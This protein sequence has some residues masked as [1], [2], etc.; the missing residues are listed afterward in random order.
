[1]S[2]KNRVEN[3]LEQEDILGIRE[4]WFDIGIS[5]LVYNEDVRKVYKTQKA[6]ILALLNQEWNK[7]EPPVGW[8]EVVANSYK[9]DLETAEQ[10][11]VATVKV[12]VEIAAKEIHKAFDNQNKN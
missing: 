3:N 1:M 7:Q 6:A 8:M 5:G 9:W 12:A 10:I 11:E 4:W 2:F